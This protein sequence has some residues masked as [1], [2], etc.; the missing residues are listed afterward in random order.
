MNDY[1]LL[2]RVFWKT[3]QAGSSTL[4]TAGPVLRHPD[5]QRPVTGN[6]SVYSNGDS[7]WTGKSALTTAADT[8]IHEFGHIISFI[9]F[10]NMQK[11]HIIMNDTIKKWVWTGPIVLQR[12]KA[13]YNCPSLVGVPLQTTSGKV[14]GHWDEEFL[15]AEMMTPST[16]IG[17]HTGASV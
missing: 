4:A 11:Q 7:N 1:D 14:G 17:E 12:A 8:M 13:Y 6:V 5:S 2:I 10:D 9:S 16:M 15:G 3:S